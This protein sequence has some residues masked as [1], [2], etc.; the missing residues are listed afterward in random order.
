MKPKIVYVTLANGKRVVRCSTYAQPNGGYLH[1]DN[2]I[3]PICLPSR[4]GA[5]PPPVGKDSQPPTNN[6]RRKSGKD[7]K[8][9]TAEARKL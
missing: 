7:V 3:Q 8:M 4:L 1:I 9:P 2:L 6:P 5:V